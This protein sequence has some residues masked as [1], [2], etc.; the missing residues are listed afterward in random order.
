MGTPD[1]RGTGQETGASGPAGRGAMPPLR[2]VVAGNAGPLTG[3]GTNTWILG[4]GGVAVIDPGPPDDPAHVAA[5]LAALAP[6][7]R[8]S[9]ILVTHPHLDHSGAARSLSAA[10]GAPV[11]GPP[12][13]PPLADPSLGGGEGRDPGYAPDLALTGGEL[14]DGAGWS[15]RALHTPGH[16][17]GHLA[18]V[19]GEVVFTGDLVMGWASTLISPP[20]GDLAA[21][22]TSVT[23]LRDLGSRMFLPGHGDPVHDPAGRAQAL[24]DHRA[25]REAALVATL[26]AGAATIPALV[27]HLYRDTPAQLHGAARRNVLAH[28]LDL[29]T[30]GMV[31]ATPTPGVSAVWSIIPHKRPPDRTGRPRT[32]LL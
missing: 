14:L 27:A 11:L 26:H 16:F 6:D 21:F 24:L 13:P 30:R 19:C 22:R 15:L 5:I 17:P 32:P 4:R 23:A 9:H 2:R 12:A 18:F 1:E 10:T 20:D 7:E 31:T 25:A 28:L 29:F 3:P 8:V